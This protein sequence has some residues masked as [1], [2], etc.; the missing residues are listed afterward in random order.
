MAKTVRVEL[1]EIELKGLAAALGNHNR[2]DLHAHM[3]EDFGPD[4][5]E[6]LVPET[7]NIFTVLMG[8]NKVHNLYGKLVNAIEEAK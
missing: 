2:K 7:D 5:A 1:T 4:A 8:E 3:T 6:E